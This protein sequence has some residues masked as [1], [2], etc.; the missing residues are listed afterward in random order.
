MAPA[1]PL[2]NTAVP[3]VVPEIGEFVKLSV[4]DCVVRVRPP[5][6]VLLVIPTPVTL[7]VP[8]IA[9]PAMAKLLAWL[10][11][12]PVTRL[13]PPRV[14]ALPVVLVIVGVE[15]AGRSVMLLAARA[16]PSPRSVWLGSNVK[17][18]FNVLA[19]K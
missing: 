8:A 15:P 17:A 4:P 16:T 9:F 2:T 1:P 12:N 19:L 13:L 10:I 18:P 11:F 14:T 3:D 7:V 6:L 5:P